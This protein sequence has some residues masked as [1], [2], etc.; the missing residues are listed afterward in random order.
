MPE[1]LQGLNYGVTGRA[2]R[3]GQ[4]AL[5]VWNLR[6]QAESAYRHV[7]DRPYGG[8]PGMVMRYEPL[9]D[10]ILQARQDMPLGARVIY[11]SPQGKVVQQHNFVDIVARCEPLIFI[12]G[13]YEGI[14][15][16]VIDA[17]VDEEWSLGDFVL[18]GGELAAMA[19]IDAM[20]RLIPGCLGHPGSALQDSFMQGLLDCPH[21]TRPA[22]VDKLS[23]PTVLL[24]GDHQQIE[25]W[26]RKQAL[27]RTY[28]R[29]P[30]YLNE[31]KLDKRDQQLLR[32]FLEELS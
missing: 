30:A 32:E 12:A 3:E 29:R 14:D 16:R 26:R 11:M 23:V 7:D 1:M 21:Y 9:R 20:M 6:D 18:S 8:G 28:L 10:A 5:H 4:A 27:G 13:R 17:H 19:C 22:T 24:T 2:I 25:T 15:E 31:M